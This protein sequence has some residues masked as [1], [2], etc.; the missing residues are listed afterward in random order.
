MVRWKRA[1]IVSMALCIIMSVSSSYAASDATHTHLLAGYLETGPVVQLNISA[2]G[3]SAADID[4]IL[5]QL[6]RNNEFQPFWIKNGKMSQTGGDIH[7][8]LLDAGS[9]GLNP[10]DY[11]VNNINQ[12]WNST[13]VSDQAQLDI[14]LTLGM[15]LYVADQREGRIQPRQLDPKLF[16]TASDVDVD[17]Q[18]LFTTAFKTSDM[19]S[20]LENQAPPFLQY[21]Q[22]QKKL[23]EYRMIAQ[24]GGW[25]SVPD[26]EVLKPDMVD[27]RVN[28]LRERLTVTGELQTKIWEESTVFDPQLVVAVEKFQQRHNLLPDGVIGRQTLAA[29]N[30]P[31]E[32]RIQ[33]I[34][35]NMERYRWLK[36]MSDEKIVAVNIA[37][38]EAVAGR[39]GKFDISMPV[40]VGRTY[41]KTPVF[42]D[43]I[44]YVEFN[45]FWNLPNSIARNETLPKLQ[46]DPTYL[47][48]QN[49]RIFQGWEEGAPE[50]DAS[51]IDWSRVSKKDMNRYRVR[52]DPGPQNALGTL[53]IMF[54]NTYNVYLHDTPTHGLFKE[55]TRAFSHGCIRMARPAEMAAYVLGG[56]EKGWSVEKVHE[57]VAT[58]KRQV[59]S[60]DEPMPVYILYRTVVVDPEDDTLYFYNDIYGRDKL[61]A[62]AL[63]A[64]NN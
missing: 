25:P 23:A 38:F 44:K 12:F 2:H 11:L 41:H 36:R 51:T 57:I 3:R 62:Q 8:V 32:L 61:L 53:K 56:A 22:L 64:D 13:D 48:K 45:P 24:K 43:T 21:R 9:Q 10:A 52:Q 40:I 6:Y 29:L 18:A 28:S 35:I 60:L 42:N 20:F 15:M 14:L 5:M 55:E 50:I 54:P 46:K 49:M 1:T 59:V 33:Q 47:K 30:V 31:V 16:A 27:V 63:F 17:W 34:I 37:G 19:K 26:G 58:G 7:T 4:E 39:P